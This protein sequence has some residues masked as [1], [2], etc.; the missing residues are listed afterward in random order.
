MDGVDTS[1]LLLSLW[2][3]LVMVVAVGEVVIAGRVVEIDGGVKVGEF[4]LCRPRTQVGDEM[5][6]V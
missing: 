4:M 1:A 5:G 6:A 3:T 2:D